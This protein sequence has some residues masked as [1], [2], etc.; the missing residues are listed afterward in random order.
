M[1]ECVV[2]SCIGGCPVRL[3][4]AT[5]SASRPPIGSRRLTAGLGG[6][7]PCPSSPCTHAVPFQKQLQENAIAHLLVQ[8]DLQFMHILPQLWYFTSN[9]SVFEPTTDACSTNANC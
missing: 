9:W 5:L 2:R 7:S 8:W 4:V 6:A 1:P 3:L